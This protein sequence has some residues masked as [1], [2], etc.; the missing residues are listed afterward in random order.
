M[1]SVFSPSSLLPL[2]TP[3]HDPAPCLY[4]RPRYKCSYLQRSIHHISSLLIQFPLSSPHPLRKCQ[5]PI[6]SVT[7]SDK[8]VVSVISFEDV[9]E[10]DW[11]FL[12]TD[13]TNSD[14][15]HKQKT[16]RIISAGEIGE[17]SKVLVSVGSEEFVDRVVE[18]SPCQQLLVVHDSLFVLAGIKE[19]CDNVNCWQGELIYVPEKWAPLDVVFLY[20]LPALPFE[21]SQIFGALA[22][23]CSPG[24]RIVISHL[25]G[26]EVLAQQRGQYADVVVSSLPDET[27]LQSAAAN[28]SFQMVEFVDEPG[29]YLVVLK[30]DAKSSAN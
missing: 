22:K 16:D 24:A 9:M 2:P 7:P 13:D 26:R 8:G 15:V 11:S 21:L 29:F 4:L 3:I 25:Q 17:T 27:T 10:K 23:R 18:S 20:F 30:F 14:E 1:N 28:H 6:S 12:E 5:L 19:K